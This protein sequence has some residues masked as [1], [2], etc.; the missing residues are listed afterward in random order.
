MKSEESAMSKYAQLWN[1]IQENGEESFKMPFAKIDQIAGA[2]FQ[3][4]QND[5]KNRLAAAFLNYFMNDYTSF[6]NYLAIS[7]YLSDKYC[8]INSFE[9]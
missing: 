4:R 2:V 7:I 8:L 6:M 1:W 5:G 9:D 3:E